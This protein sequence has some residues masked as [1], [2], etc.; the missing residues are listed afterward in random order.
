MTNNQSKIENQLKTL[1]ERAEALHKVC[2]SFED[3][4]LFHKTLKAEI[5][6]VLKSQ[7]IIEGDVAK[8]NND[9]QKSMEEYEATN[10]SDEEFDQDKFTKVMQ[11]M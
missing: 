7:Q 8:L 5:E 4:S 6:I 11:T 3:I 9:V 1:F 2:A 10:F